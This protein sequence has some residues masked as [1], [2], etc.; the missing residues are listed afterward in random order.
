MILG[1]KHVSIKENI[2]IINQQIFIIF[3]NGYNSLS[4]LL[5]YD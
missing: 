1:L 5:I 4:K 2:I 3:Y